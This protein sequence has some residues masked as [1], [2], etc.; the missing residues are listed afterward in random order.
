[1]K[2]YKFL[3][4]M[5]I[6]SILLI[7]SFLLYGCNTIG[8]WF[9]GEDVDLDD[10]KGDIEEGAKFQKEYKALLRDDFKD[11]EK[12]Y[13]GRSTSAFVFSNYDLV[14]DMVLTSYINKV[15]Q[16]TALASNKSTT[17]K[18]YRFAV[19]EDDAPNAYGTP[20]G[21]ILIS[22]G[23]LMLLDNEDELA[24][25]CAHEVE[26]VVKDHPI[27][28]VSK[29]T[30]KTALSNI[31]K[32]YA[33][34]ALEETTDIPAEFFEGMVDSFGNVL[35]DVVD[36]LDNGYEKQ[37]EFEA[38]DGAIMTLHR[39]GY[40]VNALTDVIAKLPHDESDSNYG[41]IHPTPQ[42]RI[43]AI[44]KKIDELGITPHPILDERTQRFIDNM[45]QA[46]LLG[47][48]Y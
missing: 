40:N 12:Y 21:M 16:T 14:E 13:I 23:M 20:G 45:T 30:K 10:V 19:F 8:A 1:M 22:T 25:V 32:Y 29:E 28:A 31:A 47:N 26:H 42:Q 44:N 39:A 33:A 41:S 7:T 9:R 48:T 17:Y 46:G 6:I 15:G 34:K 38:D 3:N 43:D 35:G 18:G 4:L 24:A 2:K 37:T 5:I 11:S 36:A 27:E